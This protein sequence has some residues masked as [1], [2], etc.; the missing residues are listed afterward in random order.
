MAYVFVALGDRRRRSDRFCA[1]VQFGFELVF[2][3]FQLG[4]TTV[5]SVERVFSKFSAVFA[6]NAPSIICRTNES[7]RPVGRLDEQNEMKHNKTE[8]EN[9]KKTQRDIN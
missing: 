9:E 6:C 7:K 8:K 1:C 2:V 5:L 3:A 4:F